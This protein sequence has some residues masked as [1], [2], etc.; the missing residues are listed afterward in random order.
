MYMRIFLIVFSL[1]LSSCAWSSQD[2]WTGSGSTDSIK[3]YRASIDS[4]ERIALAKKR[5]SYITGI[6]KGDFYSLRNA[7]EEALSYYLQV[8]EKLPDDQVVRKKTAHVYYLLKNWWRAYAEYIKVPLSELS[9]LE[10]KE[11][12]SALLFDEGTFDRLGELQKLP[13]STGSLEHSEMVDTCYTGIHN[14]IIAI[15]SYT[16]SESQ[17]LDLALQIKKAEKITPEYDYRNLLVAAKYYE[18]WMYRASEKIL[19]EILLDR[20][21]YAEVKK[22][23]GFSLFELGKYEEAKKY[24]LEYLDQNPKDMDSIMHLWE[25]Y[26]HLGDYVSSNLYLNNAII[27]WYTPKTN[28]ERRLAYNYSLLGDTVGMMKVLNYLI[29]EP[30]ATEDD[31]TIAISQAIKES[32]FIR[33]MSWAEQG[34]EKYK[35]SHKITPLYIQALRLSWQI[36]NASSLIQNTSEE[37][38]V[39]NP[40][41][42]LEKAII[43][44]EL[45]DRESAKKLFTDLL[46]LTDWPDITEESRVYLV[47]IENL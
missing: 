46:D 42:L 20:P 31:H 9:P 47:R 33:A 7:P 34:L 2:R 25:L 10:T 1:F 6:R 13:V 41:Y 29:Q 24:I 23:L 3:T 11:L 32:D 43:Y 12:L 18:Q 40:N 17:I 45:R 5:R 19:R 27:A 28:L 16:G 15:Q 36:D 4:D 38:M 21:D 26:F 35:N 22:I 30:D 37:A 39:E 14:C 8:Q 44:Y